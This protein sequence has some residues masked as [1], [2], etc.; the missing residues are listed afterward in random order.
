MRKIAASYILPVASKPLRNGMLVLDDAGRIAELVDTGGRLKESAR[1]EYYNGIIT[2]GF[3]LPWHR[4][5]G[6][7]ETFTAAAF[8]NFNRRLLRQGIKGIGTV[9]R[10]GAH[11][12]AKKESPITYHTI[13]ELCPKADQDEFEVFQQGIDLITGYWNEY[14]Q[15]CS[16]SCCTSSLM[17]TDIATFIIRYGTGHRQVIPL[18]NSLDWPLSEQ[19]ARLKEIMDRESEDPPEGLTLNT[20]LVLVHDPPDLHEKI[21]G[22]GPG[23]LPVFHSLVAGSEINIPGA[24]LALQ[25]KSSRFSL[26]DVLPHFTLNAAEALFE[27]D[28][29]GS[30]EPGK[31]PGL[32][33]W[34]FTEPGTLKI[35][36]KSRVKVL[37]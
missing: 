5:T 29:L 34:L 21:C 28:T 12:A 23:V 31:S 2:P 36:E 4:F 6:Q 16:L 22:E 3:V 35:T 37:V 27:H 24:M 17:K 19:L 9:E 13:L 30:I 26:P 8:R 10:K 7:R 20:H 32:N 11:F 33:L 15:V 14:G 1:L 25:R 18:E